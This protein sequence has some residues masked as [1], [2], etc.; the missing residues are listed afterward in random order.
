MK[1][2]NNLA[3]LKQQYA[4]KFQQATEAIKILREQLE[5]HNTVIQAAAEDNAA[6]HIMLTNPT[7]LSEY[8]SE[9]FGKNGPYPVETSKDRLEAEVAASSGGRFAQPQEAVPS[10]VQTTGYQR[11]SQDIP[12]PGVQAS[13]SEA[14]WSQFSQMSDKNPAMAWQIL[15]QATPEMLRSKTLVSED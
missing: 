10:G 15:N 9:F 11:P 3:E 5:K 2:A 7:V 13:G 1:Q 14:F 6:Y 4:G 8:V 12:T